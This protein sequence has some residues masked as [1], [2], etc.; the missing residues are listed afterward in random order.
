MASVSKNRSCR[1]NCFT[2]E[3]TMAMLSATHLDPVV[4]IDVHRVNPPPFPFMPHP[5][6][7]LVLDFREMINAVKGFIGCIVMNFVQENIPPEVLDI[8]DK[9]GQL[10]EVAQLAS[11]ITQGDF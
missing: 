1:N 3:L 2:G 7:G 9:A 4:G 11:A 5:H 6:V 8:V 10:G